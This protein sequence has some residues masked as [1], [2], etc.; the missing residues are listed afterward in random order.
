MAASVSVARHTLN[1]VRAAVELN[2]KAPDPR[3]RAALQKFSGWGSAAP[4]FD[5]YTSGSWTRLADELDE[6]IGHADVKAARRLVDTSF[7]TPAA[8]IGHIYDLLRAAGFNGG[9]VVDLGC[10]NARFLQHAP[11]DIPIEYTGVDADPTAIRIA[12]TLYP[13]ANLIT[14]SL[15]SVALPHNQFAAAVGNFPFS[16]ANIHDPSIDFYGSLHQYFLTRAVRAVR[17]GGYIVAITSRF[18]LDSTNGIPGAVRKLADLVAAVR[19]PSGYF[20]AEGTDVVADVLVFQVR[21]YG[22]EPRGVTSLEL[23]TPVSGKSASGYPYRLLVSNYWAQRPGCVAGTMRA[24]GAH[25]N[26]LAVDCDEHAM[27][28]TAAFESAA[29]HLFPYP[30]AATAAEIFQN[31]GLTDAEGRQEGSFHLIDGTLMKVSSQALQPVSKPSKELLALVDLRDHALRLIEAETDWERTDSSLDVLR[32]QCRNAYLDYVEQFGPLN[33]G[34]LVEG[35]ADNET[36]MPSLR[37]NTPPMGGFRKD[38]DSALVFAL[39]V[40]DQGTGVAE[41][42]PI[43]TRRVNCRPEPVD[44][45]ETPAEAF[46]VCLGEGRGLDLHRIAELLQLTD[47]TAA[48]A[49]LGDL[50]YRDPLTGNA[51][52]ARDYLSG[53]VREKLRNAL[54]AAATDPAYERNAAALEQVQPRWLGRE[55]IRIELG[56]PWVTTADIK[57]FCTEVFGA[58]SVSVKHVAPLAAWDVDGHS[59]ISADAKIFYSTTRM[60]AFQLLQYGL[61]GKP[62]VVYDLVIEPGYSEPRRVRNADDTEAAQQALTAIAERFSV[63]IWECPERERRIVETYNDTMNAH[64][65]RKDDGSYLTFPGLAQGLPLWA[66]QRDFIDR[67]LS[68]PASM[69]A[70]QVG[71]GKTRTAIALCMTLRHFKLANKP[72]YIVPNHLIEQAHREA[73]QAAPTAKILMATRDDLTR[74]NR[75]RFAARCATGD[76]DI[77]IMTHDSFSRIPVPDHVE[78]EWIEDQLL[79]LENYQRSQGTAS[80]RIATAVR[81]LR[82]RMSKLR[83]NTN[84]LDTLTFDKLGIDY[85]AVDEADR[86][87][88]LP[89]T[90]RAEGFSLGSS[91]RATD[92]FLKISLL[93]NAAHNRPHVSMFTGTPWTNTLAEAYVWQKYLDPERLNVSGLQHFDAWAAQFIR[94]EYVVEVSPDG[95]GFRSKRRPAIIQNVPELRTMLGSYMSMVRNDTTGLD[96]PIP[97]RFTHVVPATDDLTEFMASLV[98]RADDLRRLRILPEQD[99]MLKICTDGRKVALDPNLVGIEGVAPKLEALADNVAAIYHDTKHNRYPNSP[100]PGAFQLVLCDLG[101]PHPHDGQSYGRVRAALISRG[102]PADKVRFIHETA[103]SK[104]REALFAAC[105]DGRVAVLLGSTSKVG[106]GTN[107]QARLHSLHHCDPTWTARDWDQRNG[108]GI[109]SGNYHSHVRIYS[110]AVEGSFDAFMFGLAERKSR[111][112]EQLYRT[113]SDVR[114]IEDISDGTLSFA[115]LKAAAAGNPLLLRQH[116]LHTA[117]RKLRL[118]HTTVQ[119]NVRRARNEAEAAEQ[120]AQVAHSRAKALAELTERLPQLTTFEPA[121]LFAPGRKWRSKGLIVEYI[122]GHLVGSFEYRQLWQEEV[123]WATRRRGKESIQAF[124]ADIVSWWLR[125]VGHELARARQAEADWRARATDSHSAAAVIDLEP[126]ATLRA[127]EAELAEVNR[128]IDALLGDSGD[129][130]SSAA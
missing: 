117:I 29:Q 40:F 42:A 25:Q 98:S 35:S 123:P 67:A 90:T 55:E 47:I 69:A 60:S 84:D 70:H 125:G 16:S 65:L 26:P 109:R 44:H 128:Q 20:S 130:Q 45:V 105:R 43:L 101:T 6:M 78:Q 39:E 17:P 118:A 71:L 126:P 57:A 91:K 51:V 52:A 88:R 73:L 99:N 53:N 127:A 116:E 5:R 107:I 122:K 121:Y 113:D 23:S 62:P 49:A 114:E 36:G 93:R 3:Q 96:L 15:E 10:G 124:A 58:T 8:L 24:T 94:Y 56:S 120:H 79:E 75:R 102:V 28:V 76:W 18:A 64:V 104:A 34:T 100:R 129:D 4:M 48:F 103:D 89:I 108:R 12:Q 37:W 11:T 22:A 85:L 46:M 59:A 9:P 30:V 106:V 50:V 41:P 86:F 111:G 87:R 80:K 14:G 77:V 81:S 83:H 82:T 63:W 112:F 74:N 31:V 54:A 21:E 1:A 27:G 110:Y 33:R 66:W 38:P 115:E 97:E 7:Y 68:V 119:Q 2:G 32:A 72:L 13:R 61:E 95:S 92:L 19:L